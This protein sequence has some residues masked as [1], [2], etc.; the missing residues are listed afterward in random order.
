[1]KAGFVIKAL[2]EDSGEGIQ[3]LLLSRD[4]LCDL[5]LNLSTPLFPLWERWVIL[6]SSHS[7]HLVCWITSSAGTGLS[8][9]AFRDDNTPATGRELQRDVLLSCPPFRPTVAAARPRPLTA[10]A[11]WAKPGC[12]EHKR[13][14][15]ELAGPPSDRCA[16]FSMS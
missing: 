13:G 15:R 8:I 3:F 7:L 14:A 9:K 12:K 5:V 4:F 16:H 11:T 6:N 10:I 1:M 2:D